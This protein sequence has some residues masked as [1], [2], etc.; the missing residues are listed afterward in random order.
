MYNS[1]GFGKHVLNI[2]IQ[3][4]LFY[5]NQNEKNKHE[6]LWFDN[7]YHCSLISC[8]FISERN[9]NEIMSIVTNEMS[10]SFFLYVRFSLPD[11]NDRYRFFFSFRPVASSSAVTTACTDYWLHAQKPRGLKT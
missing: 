6:M 11:C 4:D 2:K 9:E 5:E 10:R 1:T 3:A 7:S 8:D